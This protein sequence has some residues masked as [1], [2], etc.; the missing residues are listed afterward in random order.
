MK[1]LI[2]VGV[3]FSLIGCS[4]LSPS[5][6]AS[7]SPIQPGVRG[8][9]EASG[10]NCQYNL[11]G[12]LPLTGALN[13]QDALNAAK[14]SA[15]SKVLTDVTIDVTNSYYVLFSNNCVHVRGLGV[16]K[17]ELDRADGFSDTTILNSRRNS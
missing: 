4:S 13:T 15:N 14:N 7:T 12:L 10:S 5:I 6:V 9:I 11:L 1:R 8:S 2:L 3:F 16:P 17:Q